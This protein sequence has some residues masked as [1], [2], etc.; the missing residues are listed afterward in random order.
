MEAV[1]NVVPEKRIV[2]LNVKRANKMLSVH[3]ENYFSGEL[4][5]K[6]GGLAT[7]KANLNDHGFGIISIR[8]IVEKY[9]GAMKISSEG[10]VFNLDILIPLEK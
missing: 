8:R 1:L 9:D 10:D 5:Y 7:S 2:S 6:E 4:R 3:E